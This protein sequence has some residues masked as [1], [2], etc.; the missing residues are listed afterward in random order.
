MGVSIKWV[1]NNRMPV[2]SVC[3]K[4]GVYIEWLSVLTECLY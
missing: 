2:I 4:K 3:I 1:A